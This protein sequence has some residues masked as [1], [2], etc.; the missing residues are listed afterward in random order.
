[1]TTLEGKVA[2]V[3]GASRGIGR[4]IGLA[5][6][7]AGATVIGTATGESGAKAFSDSL[8]EKSLKGTGVVMNVILAVIVFIVVFQ[9]PG[10][11]RQAPVVYQVDT[12]APAFRLGV[13]TVVRLVRCSGASSVAIGRPTRPRPS[14]ARSVVV[15]VGAELEPAAYRYPI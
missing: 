10:K 4:G 9:G 11:E 12:A 5:L 14:T 6:A 3:T 2:L 15:R 8:S 7:N 1:M 13:R